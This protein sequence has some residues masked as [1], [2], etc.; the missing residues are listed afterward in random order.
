[1]STTPKSFKG[2]P[3]VLIPSHAVLDKGIKGCRIS[4]TD[5]KVLFTLHLKARNKHYLDE[6]AR[7]YRKARCTLAWLAKEA[8]LAEGRKDKGKKLIWRAIKKLE[9]RE[10]IL[11]YAA[12]DRGITEFRL[13]VPGKQWVYAWDFLWQLGWPFWQV[14]FFLGICACWRFGGPKEYPHH[15]VPLRWLMGLAHVRRHCRGGKQGDTGKA[16]RMVR[17]FLKEVLDLGIF[18]VIRQA[19]DIEPM[20]VE[21]DK[22]GLMEVAK[23]WQAAGQTGHTSRT[24]GLASRAGQTGH[25]SGTNRSYLRDKPVSEIEKQPQDVNVQPGRDPSGPSPEGRD[26]KGENQALLRQAEEFR[27][28]VAGAIK[29]YPCHNPAHELP[30]ITAFIE[31]LPPDWQPQDVIKVLKSKDFRGLR[32][33]WGH[34]EAS[35]PPEDRQEM[36]QARLLRLVIEKVERRLR[37]EAEIQHQAEVEPRENFDFCLDFIQHP[38]KG[39]HPEHEDDQSLLARILILDHA[40]CRPSVKVVDHRRWVLAAPELSEEEKTAVFQKWLAAVRQK[41]FHPLPRLL[42]KELG[43]QKYETAREAKEREL[44]S[45]LKGEKGHGLTFEEFRR[46]YAADSAG[47]AKCP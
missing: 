26:L 3:Y 18:K 30:L 36:I 20:I 47:G 11:R 1:M 35:K 27:D 4:E 12:D 43:R 13:P 19:T 39:F 37:H 40:E 25:T 21:L 32:F 17:K 2:H 34:L 10:H 24:N 8:G 7:P 15:A 29:V 42:F 9:A 28:A 46:R 22:P 23:A 38:G 5:R 44:M 31:L 16:T 14:H 33:S 45:S 6:Q 41:E